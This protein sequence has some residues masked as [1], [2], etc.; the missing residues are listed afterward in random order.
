MLLLLLLWAG[1]VGAAGHGVTARFV[2]ERV[3]P[4]EVFELRVEMARAAYGRFV[5][6]VPPHPSLHRVAVESEPVKLVDGLYR[7]SEGWVLQADRAGEIV[8]EDVVVLM[9][10][11][12]GETGHPLTPLR[13]VVVP[14]EAADE[15]VVPVGFPEERSEGAEGGAGWWWLLGVLGAIAAIA[16]WWRRAVNGKATEE[17]GGAVSWEEAL[18]DLENGLL[19]SVVLE[20][21]LLAQGASWS[22]ALREAVEEAVYAGRGDAGALAVLLRKEV[23]R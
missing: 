1:V 9:T 17:V 3:R 13:M 16:W 12:D 7:Q 22:V 10:T 2:P 8:M 11:E 20:Q 6:K 19:R 14:W 18:G 23:T 15:S 21:M 4:G 5:L